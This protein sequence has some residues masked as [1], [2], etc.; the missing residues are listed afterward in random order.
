MQEIHH[1]DDENLGAMLHRLFSEG[2][3]EVEIQHPTEG[4]VVYTKEQFYSQLEKFKK[5]P[6]EAYLERK[7]LERVQ[8]QKQ[9]RFRTA[10]IGAD[11]RKVNMDT[12]KFGYDSEG[13]KMDIQG[14]A[15]NRIDDYLP[16]IDILPGE[17][18]C[19]YDEHGQ[20]EAIRIV[21]I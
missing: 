19:F 20:R 6:S 11:V 15:F 5:S 1:C 7:R 2:H 17:V 18:G 4:V 13:R 3:D 12:D 8:I 16:G 10:L 21:S 9:I 14:M